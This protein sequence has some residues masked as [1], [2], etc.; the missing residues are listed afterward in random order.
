MKN[1]DYMKNIFLTLAIGAVMAGCSVDDDTITA[2]CEPPFIARI[3]DHGKPSATLTIT[4]DTQLISDIQIWLKR[5]QKDWR[6]SLVTF[7]PGIE[8]RNNNMTLNFVGETAVLNAKNPTTGK[9]KQFIKNVDTA[10][11]GFLKTIKGQTEPTSDGDA[12]S[13]APEK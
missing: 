11:I 6:P 9:W 4:T 5:N 13:A 1:R 12:V 3:C 8:I 7:V 10:E 2:A